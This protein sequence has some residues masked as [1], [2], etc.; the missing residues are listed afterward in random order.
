MDNTFPFYL[1][2]PHNTQ[3]EN[4]AWR[5]MW[6]HFGIKETFQGSYVL[7]VLQQKTQN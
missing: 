1:N 6:N 5:N 4:N 7:T 2:S 3:P